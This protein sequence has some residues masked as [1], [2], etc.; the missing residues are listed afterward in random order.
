[1]KDVGR[2][3]PTLK[4]VMAY[5][6]SHNKFKAIL[7]LFCILFGAFVQ[8]MGTMFMRTLIDDY[9]IPMVNTGSTDFHPLF[10]RL[11]QLA[12]FFALAI[13]AAYTHQRIMVRIT[14]DTL[15][16]LREDVYSNME[17]LPIGYFDSHAH[18]DI[19]SVYTNDI[20]T[21]RQMISQTLPQ[22]INSMVTIVMA[23]VSM[24]I[25]NIPLLIIL[26]IMLQI[27]A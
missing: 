6:L 2:V 9:I 25:L 23:F 13:I 21:L 20:D 24:L 19:M 17:S 14:Q 7:V 4:R 18:G 1:M 22:C 3:W 11:L 16:R 15:H 27:E 26:L 8:I 12:C 5:T 10:M